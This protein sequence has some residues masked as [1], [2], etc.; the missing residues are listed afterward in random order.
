MGVIVNVESQPQSFRIV[1]EHKSEEFQYIDI[2]QS[3]VR[4][5][6]GLEVVVIEVK[7]WLTVVKRF[8]GQFSEA[9]AMALKSITT[10][11]E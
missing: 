5:D 10:G 2:S 3:N 4:F 11:V 9:S 7:L 1:V 6:V 8:L